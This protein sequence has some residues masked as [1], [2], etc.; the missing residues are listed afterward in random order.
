MNNK[1][2]KTVLLIDDDEDDCFLFEMALS[3]IDKNVKVKY[4]N[5]ADHLAQLLETSRPSIIVIDFYLPKI[6][7]IQCL[8]Q[9]RSF[10]GCANIPVV[11]W[12]GCANEKDI[13][14]AYLEGAQYYF[15]KPYEFDELVREMDKIIHSN[16]FILTTPQITNL[17]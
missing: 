7:G 16:R 6:S 13:S 14:S 3:S 5:S 4:T 10:P 2:I 11:L 9:I 1:N 17:N 12:S 8:Q 15:S